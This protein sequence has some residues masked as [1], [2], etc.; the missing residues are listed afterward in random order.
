M[1]T[2]L[3]ETQADLPRLVELAS[4]GED[5]IITVE[6]QAKA[7]LTRAPEPARKRMTAEEF[8][9]WKT[10]LA[11]IRETFGTGKA[12]LLGEELTEEDREDRC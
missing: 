7:R 11:E 5:V 1:T 6:G 3:S 8:E 4:H 10:E 2:T 12:G 9:A